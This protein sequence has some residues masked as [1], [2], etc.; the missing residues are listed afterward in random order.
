V[1]YIKNL[2]RLISCK[3]ALKLVK[4]KVSNPG[5]SK[6]LSLIKTVDNFINFCLSMAT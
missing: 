3:I 5:R 6:H 2:E 1:K 4:E